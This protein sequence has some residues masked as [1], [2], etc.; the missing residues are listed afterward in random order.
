MKAVISISGQ[1]FLVSKGDEIVVDRYGDKA[2]QL[3]PLMV[4]DDK[5][6]YIGQPTVKGAKIGLEIIEAE[7]KGDKVKI[8]K[9]QAKK[10]V[11]TLTGHRQP[12]TTI[13]IKSISVK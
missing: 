6:T 1:Q 8:M 11:K 10:R 5:Q 2:K 4:F 7:T 9:F 13:R 3:E 12:Q